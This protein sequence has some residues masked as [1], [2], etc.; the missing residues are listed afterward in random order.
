MR[1]EKTKRKMKRAIE[2][3][4]QNNSNKMFTRKGL[5]EIMAEAH[6]SFQFKDVSIHRDLYVSVRVCL[7]SQCIPL[8]NQRD[9]NSNSNTNTGTP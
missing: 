8:E 3:M 7:L 6:L 1:F 5:P 4:Q 9:E 2:E